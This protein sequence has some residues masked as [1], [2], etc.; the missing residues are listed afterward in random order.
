[1]GAESL[2]EAAAPETGD[3]L[4]TTTLAAGATSETETTPEAAA[5]ETGDTLETTTLAVSGMAA[6]GVAPAASVVVSSVA[7][8]FRISSKV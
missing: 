4:E 2:S 1:M 6:S 5:P 8:N 7:Q 3:K